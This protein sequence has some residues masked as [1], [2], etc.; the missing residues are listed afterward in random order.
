MHSYRNGLPTLEVNYRLLVTSFVHEW[1]KRMIQKQC[2]TT[3]MCHYRFNPDQSFPATEIDSSIFHDCRYDNRSLVSWAII[4]PTSWQVMYVS[5]FYPNC[6]SKIDPWLTPLE[7]RSEV[8]LTKSKKS[9]KLR[10]CSVRLTRDSS[11]WRP[12]DSSGVTRSI[13]DRKSVV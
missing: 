6:Q 11:L 12:F 9:S 5:L 8:T 3:R 7:L 2:L 1:V 10:C 4:T 13:T